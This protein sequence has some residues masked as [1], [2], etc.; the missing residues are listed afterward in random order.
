MFQKMLNV[1]VIG[2]VLTFA[3]QA[4]LAAEHAGGDSD[5]ERAS[6]VGSWMG[7]FENGERVLASFTS[8]GIVLSSVQMEVNATNPVLTPGHGAWTRMAG[9]QFAFTDVV[10]FYDI[11]TGELRGSGRLRGVLTLDDQGN[12]IGN[13][14][15]EVFD[16]NGALVVALPHPFRLTRI[17][18]D[19]QD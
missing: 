11:Q 5:Q 14:T 15:V 18:A 7:T 1:L 3:P 8:D 16:P 6:L 17:S 12:L 10:I 2:S 19:P 13:N 9:R 4:S